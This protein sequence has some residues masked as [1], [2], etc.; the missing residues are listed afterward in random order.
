ML[1]PIQLFRPG[2][3]VLIQISSMGQSRR[4]EAQRLGRILRA[5]KNTVIGEVNAFFYSVISQDTLEMSY[6]QG[7]S[8]QSTLGL[9]TSAPPPAQP[10]SLFAALA[11]PHLLLG[12]ARAYPRV[13]FDTRAR[14]FPLP[15]P[16]PLPLLL[17]SSGA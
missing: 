13:A 10:L 6:N 15:L 12:H 11:L 8:S 3:N 2:A 9:V 7:A 17:G 1:C 16:L 14:P 4:Q 5:K